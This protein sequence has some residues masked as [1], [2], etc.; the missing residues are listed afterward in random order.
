MAWKRDQNHEE[1]MRHLRR[2]YN[3][4]QEQ[5]ADKTNQ[6]EPGSK[7]NIGMLDILRTRQS[8]LEKELA[9]LPN[10]RETYRKQELGKY[11]INSKIF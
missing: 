10:H 6:P 3:I 4:S 2:K 9:E 11:Q 5:T 7:R 1:V 8:K